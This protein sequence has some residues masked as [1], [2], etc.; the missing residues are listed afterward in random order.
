[1]TN[2]S[3]NTRCSATGSPSSAD[4]CAAPVIA[5]TIGGAGR[6]E[7]TVIGDVVNVASRIEK[8]TKDTGDA[9]LITDA[10]LCACRATLAT[11][12]RGE[13]EVP[14]RAAHQRVHAV[15]VP[16]GIIGQPT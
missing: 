15:Q 14:G 13:V 4:G 10:T 1:M 7:F 11:M 3:G 12:D 6:Y 16:A 5:G 9:I 8:L 2:R